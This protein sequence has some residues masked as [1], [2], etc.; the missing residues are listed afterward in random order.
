MI[1]DELNKLMQTKAQI[2]QALIDKGQN[3]TDE[4]ASYV[5]NIGAIA[6]SSS[7]NNAEVHYTSEF[8]TDINEVVFDPSTR[9]VL[10]V[11]NELVEMSRTWD[12][13]NLNQ[14]IDFPIKSELGRY[15]SGPCEITF[16]VQN[17]NKL[18]GILTKDADYIINNT[19]KLTDISWLR[20]YQ[21]MNS[22]SITFSDTSNIRNIDNAF[23]RIDCNFTISLPKLES[24]YRAFYS[25]TSY[26]SAWTYTIN[27][28]PEGFNAEDMFYNCG[29]FLQNV[30]SNV[31][32]K[33]RNAKYLFYGCNKLISVPEFDLD[34][35]EDCSS[36]FN[37]CS[38]LTTFNIHGTPKCNCGAM[39]GGCSLLTEIPPNL[40]LN[41]ATGLSNIFTST[42]ITYVPTI[43]NKVMADMFYS[44]N[45]IRCDGI[46]ACD[47][48]D[49]SYYGTVSWRGNNIRYL[50]IKGIGQ[51]RRTSSYYRNISF[52]QLPNWGIEDETIPL[53]A[54]AR[55]SVIDTLITYSTDRVNEGYTGNVNMTLSAKTKALLTEEE[56]AQ[57]TAKG[58]TI[59]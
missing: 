25:K 36:M 20:K 39:F 23:G 27:D 42:G 40:N 29:N 28:I 49:S 18:S 43:N 34:D 59:A 52:S 4:F 38:K 47:N 2:K 9:P 37:N 12:F 48:V 57:I 6:T 26:N 50:V 30:N 31:V 54:G 46:N 17:C 14:L 44:S 35:C 21:E 16:N 32:W 3:P 13:Q 58:Y 7:A 33:P 15:P 24:A 51:D 55:Q 53:S 10:I 22:R 56:I 11:D 41:E 8:G 5:G 1:A 19:N 45:V